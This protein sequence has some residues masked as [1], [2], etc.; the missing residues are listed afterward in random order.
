MSLWV[1]RRGKLRDR[2]YAPNLKCVASPILQ[3]GLKFEVG[4][5]TVTTLI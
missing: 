5:V 3:G 1:T 4:H 2:D